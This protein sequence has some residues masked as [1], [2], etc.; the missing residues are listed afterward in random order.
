[1]HE[2]SAQNSL[3]TMRQNV[4]SAIGRPKVFGLLGYGLPEPDNCTDQHTRPFTEDD[5][6]ALKQ[7]LS[8]PEKICAA[9]AIDSHLLVR[10]LLGRANGR[11]LVRDRALGIANAVTFAISQASQDMLKAFL[12]FLESSD[13][14]SGKYYNRSKQTPLEFV[15]GIERTDAVEVL[16]VYYRRHFGSFERT[17]Q[18]A[19]LFSAIDS[20][21]SRMVHLL[22]ELPVKQSGPWVTQNHMRQAARIGSLEVMIELMTAPDMNINK[23][24]K[25]SSQREFFTYSQRPPGSRC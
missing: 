16:Q 22:L 12:G 2:I 11:H 14:R 15:V 9:I 21:S 25:N 8:L 17:M 23:S 6:I 3:M 18:Q 7:P 20:G 13:D 24:Y 10:Q 1:M 4:V 19:L 5:I